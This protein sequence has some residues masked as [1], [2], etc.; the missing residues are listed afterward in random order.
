MNVL[1]LK[2]KRVAKGYKQSQIANILKMT[3][4]TFCIYENSEI[5][6]FSLNHVLTLTKL[7]D[8]TLSDVNYIFFDNSLPNGNNTA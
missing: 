5:C 7:Y 1:E 8:L 6:K 4:K 3:D 2:G